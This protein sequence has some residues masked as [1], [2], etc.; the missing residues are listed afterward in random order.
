[1]NTKLHKNALKIGLMLCTLVALI[2]VLRQL[3]TS[4]FFVKEDRINILLYSAAPIYYSFEKG[5]EVHYLT[6]FNADSRTA[7]PGGYDVYRIGALGKLVALEKNPELL[8]KTFSRITG[9]MIDYY[10]YP[11]SEKIYYGSSE[12][13]KLPSIGELFLYESNANF[14]DRLYLYI[15]F[16][17]KH[18]ADFEEIHIKKIQSGDSVLL[19]DTTFARQYLGYFYHKS[20]RKE[21]KTVQILYLNSYIAAKNMSRIIDGEGIRVVDIDQSSKQ[22]TEIK[23]TQC[24]VMEN[25][26]KRYSL[27]AEEIASFFKCILTKGKGRVSDIVIEMKDG[28]NEW[29]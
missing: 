22:K 15:Q 17:G 1:M 6:T 24:L 11:K 27:T 2:I 21:N 10:L 12:K 20:L 8:K 5:G 14:F 23:K 4:A 25:T 3:L 16:F 9:S 7:V 13:I 29:E 28:E 26:E 19:S 18:L